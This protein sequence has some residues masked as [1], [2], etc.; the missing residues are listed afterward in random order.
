MAKAY[1]V[2][3]E[4][5]KNGEDNYLVGHSAYTYLMNPQGKFLKVFG[6]DFSGEDMAQQVSQLMKQSV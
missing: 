4:V 1:R 2:Y 6:P 3:Y 5:P